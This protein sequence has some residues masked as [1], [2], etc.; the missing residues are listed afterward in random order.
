MNN[1]SSR[2][3]ILTITFFELVDMVLAWNIAK[4]FNVTIEE[5]F[6]VE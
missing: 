3:D 4:V 5:I 6:N 1:A 2:A